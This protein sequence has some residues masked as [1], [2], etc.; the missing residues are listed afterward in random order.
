MALNGVDPAFYPMLRYSPPANVD[1][2]SLSKYIAD[3]AGAGA[4]LFPD[5]GLE[6]YLRDIAGLPAQ[7][8]E[9]V[10]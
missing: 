5:E 6:S 3:L 4:M 8:A 7:D 10:E 2:E 1:L 9:D